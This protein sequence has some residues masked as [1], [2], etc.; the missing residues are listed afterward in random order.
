MN[1]HWVNL[2]PVDRK[3]FWVIVLSRVI[4]FILFLPRFGSCFF[5]WKILCVMNLQAAPVCVLRVRAA[6][7]MTFW[8][9]AVFVQLTHV[10]TIKFHRLLWCFRS[11]TRCLTWPGSPAATSWCRSGLSLERRSLGKP[12]SRCTSRS[13]PF[14][15]LLLWLRVHEC[16]SY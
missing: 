6:A 1:S 3:F 4:V 10:S 7:M 16:A 12:L 15:L 11:R 5:N 13:E 9:C 8:L 2:P 14:L